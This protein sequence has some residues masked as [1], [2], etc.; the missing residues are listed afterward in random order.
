LDFDSIEDLVSGGWL[1]GTKEMNKL[2]EDILET[3]KKLQKLVKGYQ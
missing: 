2:Q 1:Y 3:A